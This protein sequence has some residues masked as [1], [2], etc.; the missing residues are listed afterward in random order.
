M[1]MAADSVL[2]RIAGWAAREP[3]RPALL[4]RDG[5]MSYGA[6]DAAANGVAAALRARIGGGGGFAALCLPRT[7]ARMAAALGI[8][9]AGLGYV[10]LD[11]RLHAGGLRDLAAHC[12]A[13]AVVTDAETALVFGDAALVAAGGGAL[14]PA[15][16]APGDDAYIRYTS[17][18]T[19]QPKGVLHNHR[20]AL[21]QALA[22]AEAL[23]LH[24]DD[25]VSTLTFFPHALLWGVLARGAALQVVDP[26]REGLRSIAARLRR[27]RVTVLCAFPSLM[28][29]LA[30][31]LPEGER[32][33]DMRCLSLSG[34]PVAA[35]DVNRALAMIRPGGMVT[36]E[37]G[38]SEFVQVAYHR[39]HEPLAADAAVPA[40]RPP[41]GV[42]VEL[43]GADGVP[44]AAGEEGEICVRSAFMSSGYWRQP[45]LT[46]AVFGS[47]A[48]QDGTA[49]YRTG[50]L[51]RIGADGNLV[52]AGR[53]DNQIKLRANRVTPEEIEAVLLRH[54]DVA[55]AA[56][57]AF[58]TAE[59]EARL[60]AFFVARD[61][62]GVDAAV[63]RRFVGARLPPY[64]VPAVFVRV[65]ALPVTAGGKLDRAALA[66]Q[67]HGPP[68][69]PRPD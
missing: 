22:C 20:A 50:D 59:G 43:R 25:A 32:F 35:G 39:M 29:S 68:E 44:V 69:A 66:G 24:A 26:A 64:M 58:A 15:S 48:P 28:R 10:P 9:R 13:R 67:L 30:V 6:L 60:T 31:A 2:A 56:V 47:T 36:N 41:A 62:A 16:P 18:S 38:T 23:D 53:V 3:E 21:G 8:M 46:R 63:L 12:Q 34:E 54:P 49:F 14:V 11:P 51:G 5:T 1:V 37:Y 61:G 27:E 19:G 17:G 40:G 4:G 52:V 57:A 55:A 33:A 65:D 42:T 45:D 7:P